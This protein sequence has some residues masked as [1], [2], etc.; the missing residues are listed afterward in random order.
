MH[1][2]NLLAT[3]DIRQTHDHLTVET[4]RTQQSR[5]EHVGPVRRRNH[6]DAVVRLEAVHLD[7]QLVQ[8]LFAFVVTAAQTRAAVPTDCVDLVD[9][10]DARR[11]LL[12]LL[13]HVAHARRTDA[14]EHLDEVGTG[15]GEERYF[16]F[17]G[18]RFREQR[19]TGT[20]R[21]DHQ[22]AARNPP[23][24]FLELARVAQKVDE[25]LHVFFRFVDTGNVGER[26]LD[27]IL[28]QQPCLALAERHR[29][30][31]ATRAALHLTHEQHEHGDDDEDREAGDQQLR[32]DALLLRRL[33][34]DADVVVDQLVH[35]LRI[36]DRRANDLELF[37][38]LALA[39]DHETV[40]GDFMH[41][42]LLDFGDEARVRDL[43][44]L[45]T[46]AEVVEHRQ[47]HR[48][49]DQPQK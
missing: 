37:A 3:A 17:A 35:Q 4:A 20:R 1:F 32:P 44:R 42:I 9:E 29:S 21:T 49:D 18:D 13:E 19:L 48:C 23:A 7:Q 43:F 27:L 30:A 36:V 25:F 41:L 14:D 46:H 40:D 26:G 5:I 2:Q 45:R 11:L 10:D 15:N 28:G 47:Q 12:R 33:T 31:A 22:N 34:D 16:C 8:R 24:E 38:G 39:D 6:D